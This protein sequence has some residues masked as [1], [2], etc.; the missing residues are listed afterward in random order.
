LNSGKFGCNFL[1]RN[2]HDSHAYKLYDDAVSLI[3]E[4]IG[5]YWNYQTLARFKKNGHVLLAGILF[6]SGVL[7]FYTALVVPI[8]VFLWDDSDPCTLFP[9]LRI[10]LFVDTFFLVTSPVLNFHLSFWIREYM[11]FP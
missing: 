11:S 10:D 3:Q 1:I 9:T 5:S 4:A 2:G 7:L 8:Q 6:I